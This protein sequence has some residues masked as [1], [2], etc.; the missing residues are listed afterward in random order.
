MKKLTVVMILIAL[1]LSPMFAKGEV[2]SK[3]V[4]VE[5]TKP[6]GTVEVVWWTFHGKT[7]VGYFQKVIEALAK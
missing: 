7:N 6:A 4:E 2:E 5:E 3:V 1:I